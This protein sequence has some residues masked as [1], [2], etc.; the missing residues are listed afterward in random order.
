MNFSIFIIVSISL[1]Q[2]IT[3][4]KDV[5]QDSILKWKNHLKKNKTKRSKS[6]VNYYANHIATCNLILAGDIELNPGPGLHPKPKATK[7][8]V[9]DKA[10]SENRKRMKCDMCHNLMHVSCLSISKHQQ[11][12]H[13]VKT[14]PL[15]TC[16]GGL[17]STLLFLETRDLNASFNTEIHDHPPAKTPHLK[18]LN[19]NKNNAS[20]AHL[21]VEALMST[22]NEC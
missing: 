16:N 10:I 3:D 14:V 6:W 7:C 20:I 1:F 21:N 2:T 18:K 17:L 5:F 8:N 15:I 9:C 12:N 11:E 4:I 19:E 22:F 13:T